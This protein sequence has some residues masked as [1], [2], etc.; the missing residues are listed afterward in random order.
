MR[1]IKD[2]LSDTLSTDDCKLRL[3]HPGGHKTLLCMATASLAI[4][5]PHIR[6]RRLPDVILSLLPHLSSRFTSAPTTHRR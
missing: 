4:P 3:S 6:I 5:T 1:I 2:T